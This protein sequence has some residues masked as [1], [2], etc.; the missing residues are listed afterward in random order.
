M[1][2]GEFCKIYTPAELH[3]LHEFINQQL[4]N[5]DKRL[6]TILI[7]IITNIWHNNDNVEHETFDVSKQGNY[8]L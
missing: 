6:A 8:K 2:I 3:P 7:E 5:E 1:I 4:A